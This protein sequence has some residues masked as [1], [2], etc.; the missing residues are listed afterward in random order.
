MNNI[1]PDAG[2]SW[3]I[4]LIVIVGLFFAATA[5]SLVVAGR[6]V[7][8]VVDTEYYSHGL[9][10]AETHPVA[11][12]A[13][14][15]WTVSPSADANHLQ[16]LVRDGAGS[17][18]TGGLLVYDLD[19]PA[20]NRSGDALRLSESSPGI[21]RTLRPDA[22]GGDLRGTMRFTRGGGTITGRVVVIN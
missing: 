8:R 10:Y 22:A 6:K 4:T 12:N 14:A 16:V 18:V 7:S 17:P 2:T 11:G 19:R 21:Y 1:R 5:A 15:D 20:G 9:H 13:G 3:K